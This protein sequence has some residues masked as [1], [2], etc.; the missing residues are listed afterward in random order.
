MLSTSSW[1]KG[2]YVA[3]SL[4]VEELKLEHKTTNMSIFQ[5]IKGHNSVTEKLFAKVELVTLKGILKNWYF[6]ANLSTEVTE[7]RIGN[8]HFLIHFSQ[9]Y[10]KIIR[11]RGNL[12]TSHWNLSAQ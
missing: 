10:L 5:L 9:A 8:W 6:S 11:D 1:L 2:T 7:Q 4:L 12:S 3:H